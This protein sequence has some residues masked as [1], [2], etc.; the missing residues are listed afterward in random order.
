[1]PLPSFSRMLV[2]FYQQRATIFLSSHDTER[3]QTYLLELLAARMAPP[4]AGGD[5]DW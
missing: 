1:M 5:Y 4:K 3:F 2:K